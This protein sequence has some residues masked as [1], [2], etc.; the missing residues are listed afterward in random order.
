VSEDEQQRLCPPSNDLTLQDSAGIDRQLEEGPS[1]PL[2]ARERAFAV[3]KEKEEFLRSA[4]LFLQDDVYPATD[5]VGR[6]LNK[7][8]EKSR[9]LCAP[10]HILRQGDY[11][12]LVRIDLGNPSSPPRRVVWGEERFK[13][14]Q[15]LHEGEGN[16]GGAE[17]TRL[18]VADRYWFPQLTD[19]VREFVKTCDVCQKER[20]GAAPPDDREIF[21]TP[22]TAPWFRTHVDLCG[23]FE[24]SGPQKFHYIAVAVDSVTKFVEVR[25]LRGSKLKGVDSEEVADFLQTKILHR[26]PGVYEVVSD[27]GGEFGAKFLMLCKAWGIKHVKIAAKNPKASGQVERY[28]RVI[29]PAVRSAH[30]HP[31]SGIN[32]SVGL[33]VICALLVQRP[34]KCRPL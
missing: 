16:Y 6:A 31:G 30:E 1:N 9:K 8:R 15:A 7:F 5:K 10:F 21:P 11:D 12:V 20:V 34:L 3:W 33:A 29:K 18:K 14:V 23:P 27:R 22:P 13:V 4:F 24:E 2:S 17:K 32:M 25:P 28:M 26:H 19:F